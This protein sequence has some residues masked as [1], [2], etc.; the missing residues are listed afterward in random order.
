MGLL[1]R[2]TLQRLFRYGAVY[3]GIVQDVLPHSGTT[4]QECDATMLNRVLKPGSKINVLL[5]LQQ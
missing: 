3:A 1:L 2:R 4:V 5:L